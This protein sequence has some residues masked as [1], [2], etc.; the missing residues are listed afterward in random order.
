MG[1]FLEYLS[2]KVGENGSNKSP[3]SAP[4]TLVCSWFYL[5]ASASASLLARQHLLLSSP[6]L[7][8]PGLA[9]PCCSSCLVTGFACC[10]CLMAKVVQ[11]L[12]SHF[13]PI[14]STLLVSHFFLQLFG[15]CLLLV[16]VFAGAGWNQLAALF[17]FK[18]NPEKV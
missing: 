6:L 11:T 16:P 8:L 5:P 4:P 1:G 3:G 18:C 12:W 13:G 17:L 9:S 15:I 10:S 7:H 2:E 14:K